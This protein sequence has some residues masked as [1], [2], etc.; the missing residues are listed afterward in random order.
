MTSEAG[1]QSGSPDRSSDRFRA[2]VDAVQD[3]G[4]FMLDTGGFVT[5]WNLGAQRIK[6]YAAN[7][8]IGQHFSLFYP[9]EA[10]R[11]RWPDEELK[12]AIQTGRY[13]EEGWRVRKDG[14]RFWAS[15]LITALKTPQ[16]ELTG[17]GKVTRDLTERRNYE[18]AMRQSEERFRLLVD[19]VHDYAIYM[20][21]TNGVIQSWNRGAE[22]IKGYRADEVVGRHYGMFFR[23][24]DI[25]RSLPQQELIDALTKGRTEEEGWRLRKDGSA[26][27]ANIVMTPIHGPDGGLRGFAKVTRDMTERQRLRELEHSSQR[28]NEF[29]AM[30]AHELRNPLAPIRNAVSI[31]QMEAA[32]SP[33]LRS[34]RDMI[35]RQLTHMTRLVD[36]LLDAGRLTSGKIRIRLERVSFSDIAARAAEAV[37]P[38]MEARSHAFRLELPDAEIWVNADAIRLAQ[39]LQNLLGNAVKFTP[40]GGHIVLTANLQGETL[41]VQVRDDGEGFSQDSA[42]Q[43]FE[44]FAQGEGASTSRE[45]GLG[46]GLALARS[47]VEM[48]GGSIRAASDGPGKGS[49]F[50]FDLPGASM[51]NKSGQ[52]AASET[53]ALVVDDNRDSADSLSELLRLLGLRVSTAYSGE[54]ALAVAAR[55]RPIIVFL[56]LNMPRMTGAELLARLKALPGC[57]NV[58]GVAVTGYGVEDEKAGRAD[59]TG[60]D[61]RLMKPLEL[62]WLR[63]MLLRNRFVEP[64]K[65]D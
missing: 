27:W 4:I 58:F 32:P 55:E 49:V 24:E 5:S 60:F 31:L 37:R 21:D 25:A 10:R 19:G 20:L 6:G 8:V 39:I 3:Y 50:A 40:P 11:I 43:L 42:A 13:E 52:A 1:A 33:S 7:E 47:L 54:T 59:F 16:G 17:F 61:D 12:R 2:L 36:D 53:R 46:I 48:H 44:L 23:A 14:S 34:S 18:E 64:Q 57:A 56:D 45:G 65:P 41:T 22:L 26:F 35:D 9:E 38:A 15:V 63:G 62:S 30:L 29:L 51:G 28:M